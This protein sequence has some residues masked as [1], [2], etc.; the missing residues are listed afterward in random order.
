MKRKSFLLFLAVVFPLSVFASHPQPGDMPQVKIKAHQL[1]NA[2]YLVASTA[3]SY[4]WN[5]HYEQYAL[6][7][8]DELTQAARHFHQQVEQYLGNPEHTEHDFER[9]LAAYHDAESTNHYLRA[10]N[11]SNFRYQ[12]ANVTNLLHELEYYYEGDGHNPDPHPGPYPLP[13]NVNVNVRMG[14]NFSETTLRLDATLQGNQL[15]FAGVYVD[16]SLRGS[17][18]LN[19]WANQQTIYARV[20]WSR[21]SGSHRVEIRVRQNHGPETSVWSQTY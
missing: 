2:T 20:K 11:Y 17:F 10:Y 4:S 14:G 16:G 15:T 3:R 18:N 21:F 9:L 6:E 5:S 19:P 7:H 8:L 12:W 13:I 1:E